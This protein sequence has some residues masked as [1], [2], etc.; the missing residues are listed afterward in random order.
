MSKKKILAGQESRKRR[1]A[2]NKAIREGRDP[3]PDKP[4]ES[5]LSLVKFFFG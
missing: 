5:F 3:R 4:R 2:L 1:K